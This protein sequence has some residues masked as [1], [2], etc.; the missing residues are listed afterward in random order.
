MTLGT[1]PSPRRAVGIAVAIGVVVALVLVAAVGVGFWYA[2]RGNG[3]DDD[4]VVQVDATLALEPVADGTQVHLVL[5]PTGEVKAPVRVAAGAVDEPY[6]IDA[7]PFDGPD[8][9]GPAGTGKD[10][11]W[12]QAQSGGQPLG[13]ADVG[14][15]PLR[16]NGST[17]D[18]TALVPT[19]DGRRVV[20]VQGLGQYLDVRTLTVTA[21]SG[22]VTSCL[23]TYS[24][25]PRRAHRVT[26]CTPSTSMRPE[27][28]QGIERI[29]P[30]GEQQV[31]FE[32]AAP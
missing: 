7:P 26:P 13:T 28:P 19:V 11:E 9:P 18:L 2:L 30:Q 16:R 15:Q 22:A 23:I 21:P 5:R 29:V 31:R 27:L 10:L 14:F 8:L 12:T 4:E 17:Y 32:L 20:V 3:P 24:E 25:S 1:Q 6:T